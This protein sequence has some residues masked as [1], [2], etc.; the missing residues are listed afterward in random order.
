MNYKYT[1]ADGSLIDVM[2]RL[3][4]MM[5]PTTLR[6]IIVPLMIV[7]SGGTLFLLANRKNDYEKKVFKKIILFVLIGMLVFNLFFI[8]IMGVLLYY[9]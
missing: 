5:A 3:F 4:K 7:I 2:M 9:N 1:L 8:L 6:E